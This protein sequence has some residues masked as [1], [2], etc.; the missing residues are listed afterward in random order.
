MGTGLQTRSEAVATSECS[1]GPVAFETGRT[2]TRM[3]RRFRRRAAV[4]IERTARA[5]G[6]RRRHPFT[7]MVTIQGGG[8]MTAAGAPASA[9]RAAAGAGRRRRRTVELI[10]VADTGAGS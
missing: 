2:T 4:A 8:D 1:V 6:Q 7:A 5:C 9:A 3:R 10:R